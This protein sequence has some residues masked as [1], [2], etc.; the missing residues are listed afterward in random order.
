MRVYVHTKYITLALLLALLSQLK[1]VNNK[2][3][4]WETR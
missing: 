3:A 4:S 1:T 2:K